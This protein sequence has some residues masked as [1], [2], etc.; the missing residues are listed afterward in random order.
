MVYDRKIDLYVND[1][2]IHHNRLLINRVSKNFDF[3]NNTAIFRDIN[4]IQLVSFYKN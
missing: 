1:V 3:P 4:Y 2:Y